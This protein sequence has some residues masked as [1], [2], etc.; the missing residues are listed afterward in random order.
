M[1]LLYVNPAGFYADPAEMEGQMQRQNETGTPFTPL[2]QGRFAGYEAHYEV[3][4][5]MLVTQYHCHDYYELYIHLRGG[6]YMGVDNKLYLLKP[7]QIFIIPPF[8]MH[9]L[10]C[11]G[12][13]QGYE[14]AYLNLSPEVMETLGCG[15]VNLGDYLQSFTARGQY[16]YQLDENRAKR[17]VQCIRMIRNDR[18]R[19]LKPT[20][21]FQHYARMIELLSLICQIMGEEQPEQEGVVSNS[22]I[23]D[24]L[25]YINN[26]Y[27]EELRVSELARSFN[28]SESYLSHEF[29]RF[30]NRSVYDYILYRRIMLSKQMMM[31]EDSLN[32]IA[33]RCGFNDYSNYLRSFSRL[34]GMPPSQYRRGL[35]Q[36]KNRET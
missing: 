7:N 36:F 32:V 3:N 33:F 17:F 13:L 16:T 34:A 14:R 35:K 6:E 20:E 26:H 29:S 27:T 21:R 1:L 10:S 2:V 23:Q 31:G 22:V 30:T 25:S 28:I 9:G 4:E 12:E 18:D 24:V 8:Y 15:Q 5:R 11:T 19:D